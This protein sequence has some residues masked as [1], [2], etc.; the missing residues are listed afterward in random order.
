M[1]N[2]IR[3]TIILAMIIVLAGAVAYAGDAV[4]LQLDGKEVKTEVAPI[5]ESSR[6]LIPYRALLESMGAVVSWEPE[7]RTATAIL[8]DSQVKVTI[9]SKS[10]FVNGV[11]KEIDVPPRIVNDRTMI[12]VRFVLENLNCQVG[13]EEKTRTVTITSPKNSSLTEVSDI[14]LEETDSSYRIIARGSG[15]IGSTRTFSYNDPERYG[16]DIYDARL[17]DKIGAINISNELFKGVRYSQFDDSTVRL[18]VD[19]KDKTSG[20]V[21]LS[22]DKSTI[23][24]DF[25]KPDSA[26]GDDNEGDTGANEPVSPPHVDESVMNQL[27]ALD[28]RATGRLIAIDAGHGGTDPGSLGKINGAIVLKEKDINLKIA[29][30]LRDL[31]LSAGANVVL[32]REDDVS[33]SLYSR[34]E[35]A[36]ALNADLLISVHNN[37]S[38]FAAP[39]GTEVHYYDKA[40]AANCGI[41]SKDLAA[42]VQKELL[43]EIGLKDR[44]IKS[45]PSLAVLNKSLMPAII[46]EGAFLSNQSDLQ[47][48]M[49]DS[50][51]E[52]YAIATARGVINELNK[53]AAN[54]VE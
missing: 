18:V 31:L 42:S 29:L 26:T 15:S 34:P 4:K 8:A 49:K 28:W 19:L 38:E 40:S 33:M 11:L 9:D 41:T 37:S 20:R 22:E 44:G 14:R 27:P 53:W 45:S 25:E 13:W 32:M 16:I 54:Q 30:R 24:I 5:I 17:A 23:Y 47:V 35:M 21:S 51:A 3:I 1:K 7:S 46:I 52:A 43:K 36:N 2:C 50:F 39:T 10:A 48:M 6:T 12:P